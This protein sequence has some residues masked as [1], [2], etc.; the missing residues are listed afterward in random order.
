MLDKL[1]LEEVLLKHWA[2]FLDSKKLMV[3]VLQ[4]ASDAA[5]S[6]E[7]AVATKI[8][9][10]IRISASRFQ[11]TG[12]GFVIWME[13]TVPRDAEVHLGTA[14]YLLSFGGEL[15][16]QQMIGTRLTTEQEPA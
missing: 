8:E 6:F 5:E 3:R 12:D 14:E 16:L 15:V 11:L 13:F 10:S 9:R 4:D 2:S 1:K 7:K